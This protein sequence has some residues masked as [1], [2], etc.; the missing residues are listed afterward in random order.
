MQENEVC[1]A[2][3]VVV[4]VVEGLILALD[5]TEDLADETIDEDGEAL[6]T[7]VEVVAATEEL[8]TDELL[9]VVAGVLLIITTVDAPV[10]AGEPHGVDCGMIPCR[11]IIMY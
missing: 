2:A 5:I 9:D 6:A 1:A 10:V 11:G 8:I 7:F 3:V 4:E